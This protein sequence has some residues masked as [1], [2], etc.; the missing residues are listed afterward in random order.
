MNLMFCPPF[1]MG[2]NIS[3][4]FL[5]LTLVS[6]SL[7]VL[8]RLAGGYRSK[9]SESLILYDQEVGG[10]L[11]QP[12]YVNFFYNL[13]Q[14]VCRPGVVRGFSLFFTVLFRLMVL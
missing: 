6:H 1:G 8:L 11:E 12:G 5:S 4:S 10:N 7:F 3:S 2:T 14:C 13:L 9:R